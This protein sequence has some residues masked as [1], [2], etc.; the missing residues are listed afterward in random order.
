MANIKL[1]VVK[2]FDSVI[3]TMEI[4]Q[5]NHT[6]SVK[7]FFSKSS[8]QRRLDKSVQEITKIDMRAV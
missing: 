1:E 4:E 6:A 7:A 8:T 2:E 3:E 5:N